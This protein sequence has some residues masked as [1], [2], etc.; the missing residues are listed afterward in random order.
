MWL[1]ILLGAL[2]PLGA[3]AELRLA[4]TSGSEL[5]VVEGALFR[6]R[7][8]ARAPIGCSADSGSGRVLALAADP[9]GLTFVAAEG[10]LFVLGPFVDVLDPVEPEGDAPRGRPTAVH[11]DAERRVWF[12][13]AE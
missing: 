9:A 11:V 7:G 1:S 12:A 2:A 8:G 5:V 13:T 3:R 4:E 6:E 10:G